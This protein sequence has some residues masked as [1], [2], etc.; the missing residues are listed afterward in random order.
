MRRNPPYFQMFANSLSS[1][2]ASD[3]RLRRFLMKAKLTWTKVLP[4]AVVI[5]LFVVSS[6]STTLTTLG[7]AD[8]V[9]L[10]TTNLALG[11][12]LPPSKAPLSLNA[13]NAVCP[14]TTKCTY[15]AD[16]IGGVQVF[17]GN[18]LI[19]S[20]PVI[21]TPSDPTTCPE[22]AYAW[23]GAIIVSDQCG[24]NGSGELRVLKPATNTWGTPISIAGKAPLFMVG[25]PSNGDLYVTN[26]GQGTVTVLSSR[27]SVAGTVTTCA[28]YPMFLDYDAASGVVFVG[29]EGFTAPACVDMIR[30]TTAGTP[31][32]SA[33]THVFSTSDSISGVTVN[34][35]TGNVYVNDPNYNSFTGMVFEYGKRGAYKTSI[36]PPSGNDGI[37][38]NAYDAAT[39]S[40]YVVSPAQ[41]NLGVFNSTGFVF[42]ISASNTVSAHIF[43]GVGPNTACYNP[44]NHEIYAP[45]TQE[46]IGSGVTVV[47]GVIAHN[48]F[49]Y[50][51]VRGFGCG[52]N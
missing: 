13:R 10:N 24:N 15:V 46:V 47:K 42:A 12:L 16:E 3:N 43:A 31:I 32:T 23:F 5:V 51:P 33:G 45:N 44:A 20:I 26:F 21:L 9:S 1:M 14:N 27:T 6:P 41:D 36:T 17:S 34:Q 2:K 52:A 25:N 4:I 19:A 7:S 50:G 28:P 49:V 37:W 38:G 35:H 8:R 18:N 40:V 29:N 22:G 11:N 39:Q 30:G 48:I